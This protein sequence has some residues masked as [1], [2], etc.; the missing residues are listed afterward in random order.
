[1]KTRVATRTAAAAAALVLLAGCSSATPEPAP[2]DGGEPGTSTGSNVLIATLG[3]EDDPDAFEIGL[4]DEAGEPVTELPAGDYVIQ[5]RDLSDIHNWHLRGGEVDEATE[6]V[7]T[8]EVTWEITLE[9]GHYTY[10]CDPHPSMT[11]S[12]DVV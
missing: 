9:P 5:V 12:F 3:T 1:M 7:G 8:E 2:A 10:T 11:G 4:T 6:V